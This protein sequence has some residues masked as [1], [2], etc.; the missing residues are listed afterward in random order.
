MIMPFH[1]DDP[2][3]NRAYIA[4]TLRH[5]LAYIH[6]YTKVFENSHIFNKSNLINNS[7]ALEPSI[8]VGNGTSMVMKE[9]TVCPDFEKLFEI[10]ELRNQVIK[11]NLRQFSIES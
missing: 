3:L 4:A 5:P 1:G 9:D 6:S 10:E 8:S 2:L 11:Q 7:N